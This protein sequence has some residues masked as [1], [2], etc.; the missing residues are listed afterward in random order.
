MANL[1]VEQPSI[2]VLKVEISHGLNMDRE[3]NGNAEDWT[4]SES[5]VLGAPCTYYTP[6][7][8][9]SSIF[10]FLDS[11]EKKPYNVAVTALIESPMKLYVQ[12]QNFSSILLG[13]DNNEMV[14]NVV[15]FET[16][17]RWSDLT[18]VI[19]T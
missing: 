4:T 12:N 14:K 7:K 16:N 1:T 3:T 5:S 9:E 2:K 18:D 8:D 13:N 6:V 17:L 11:D 19:P 15:R 10:D